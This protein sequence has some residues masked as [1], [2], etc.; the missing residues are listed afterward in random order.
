MSLGKMFSLLSGL[1]SK[2]LVADLPVKDRFPMYMCVHI[3][4][5]TLR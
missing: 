4:T 5:N 2:I 3:D 1:V